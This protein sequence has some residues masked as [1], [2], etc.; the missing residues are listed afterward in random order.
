M[1]DVLCFDLFTVF[2]LLPRVFCFRYS[3]TRQ[4]RY[5]YKIIRHIFIAIIFHF[6][7]YCLFPVGKLYAIDWSQNYTID[8]RILPIISNYCFQVEEGKKF[9]GFHCLFIIVIWRKD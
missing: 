6:I 5:C 3:F 1:I 4:D 9:S 7:L 8:R 2:F